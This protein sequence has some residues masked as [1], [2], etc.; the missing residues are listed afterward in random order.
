M[1]SNFPSPNEFEGGFIQV[2][3]K[4]VVDQQLDKLDE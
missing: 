4:Q 2:D 1:V 3:V